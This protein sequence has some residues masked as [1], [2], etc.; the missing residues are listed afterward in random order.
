MYIYHEFSL[1]HMQCIVLNDGHFTRD[2]SVFFA[3]APPDE[4][5]TTLRSHGLQPDAVPSWFDPLYVD[6]GTNRV[7]ID[8]GVGPSDDPLRGRLL[9][10]MAAADI[11]PEDIDTVIITHGH[12]DH[13]GGNADSAGQPAFPNAR[14]YISQ[15][16]WDY[17]AAPGRFEGQPER[18]EFFQR[19]LFG[20]SEL[21][22]QVPAG[23]VIV[24]G[25]RSVSAFGHSAGHIAL[26]ISDDE[27]QLLHLGDALHQP[28]HATYP[29]W[30]PSFDLHPEIAAETRRQLLRHAT[31][32]NL[33]TFAF[34]FPFPG[35]GRFSPLGESWT[36]T[37][38][39]P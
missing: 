17:W 19:C 8:T 23:H 6:T 32:Q 4:R 15:E 20:M 9:Q 16:E 31:A 7:L 27:D 25:I 11:K 38:I 22:T 39:T 14:Y 28:L 2:S 13:I 18:A 37:P 36:W 33:L 5:E 34:H 12:G 29:D 35:L 26:E 21:F 24:P 10:S 3:G 1:G 30:G